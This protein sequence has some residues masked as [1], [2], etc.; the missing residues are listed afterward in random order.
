LEW[1]RTAEQRGDWPEAIRRWRIVFGNSRHLQGAIGV[2]RG[3]EELG[4]I[5]EAEAWLL[6]ARFRFG[7]APEIPI[8]LAR[9]AEKRGDKDT[10]VARWA[11]VVRRFPKL[12]FG[13]QGGVRLLTELGR[14]DEVA[15]LLL[16]AIDQFPKADWPA[17][18]YAWQAHA[19]KDWAAAETRWAAVR[20]GW[21]D[22]PIGYLRGADALAALGRKPEAEQLRDEARR[23]FPQ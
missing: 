13:Y 15:T 22:L 4:R 10:A 19:Q 21:P 3:L 2:A 6:E 5:E 11:D 23:R 18:T 7:Q 1:A 14:R 12:I 17:V 20:A 16:A 9:L 8:A